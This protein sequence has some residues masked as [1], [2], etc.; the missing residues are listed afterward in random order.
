MHIVFFFPYKIVSGV[1]VLFATLA[2]HISNNHPKIEVSII[3]YENGIINQLIKNKRIN[4]I[5]FEDSKKIKV[6]KD[7]ILILQSIL[8]FSLRPELEINFNQQLFFWNLH[9]DCLILNNL[10]K[11]RTLDK[12]INKIRFTSNLKIKSFIE[13]CMNKNGLVFMDDSNANQTLNYYRINKEPI[14]LQIC[15]RPLNKFLNK[16]NLNSISLPDTLKFT[17]IGRV[18]DFKYHPLK[19]V[20][21]SL[22]ELVKNKSINKKVIFYIIGD[23]KMINE[24]KNFVSSNINNIKVVFL[25]VLDN[26]KIPKFLI[27]NK[28][29][30][31][32]AMGTSV[33]DSIQMG[34]PTILLNYSYI[35]INSYPAYYF[36]DEEKKFSLG[37]ELNLN[38]LSD[39]NLIGLR[40]NINNYLLDPNKYI[41]NA[42]NYAE[43]FSVNLV[44]DKFLKSIK[45]SKLNYSD[46]EKYF[47]KNIF[48]RLYNFLKYNLS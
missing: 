47:K 32:F 18:V 38:D 14:F 4:R 30:I 31:N 16:R 46:V 6:P 9:P 5:K 3:D 15:V 36:A 8:P 29:D 24:L 40:E 17:Y 25:G 1:P 2:E 21:S 37:R 27:D 43:E 39:S 12:F 34:V 42:L 45:K 48:R 13:F 19:K 26:N 7:S 44:G 28:I 41:S 20:I 11:I 22:S 35:N 10:T 23:G 33:L